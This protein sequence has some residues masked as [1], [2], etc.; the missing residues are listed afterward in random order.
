MRIGALVEPNAPANYRVAHP[1]EA[2]AR[3]GHDVVWPDMRGDT[4]MRELA[5]CDLVV[6]YRRCD[7]PNRQIISALRQ[8]GVAVIWDNDDDL[9]QMPKSR[10]MRRSTGGLSNQ[11]LFME[12][13]KTARLC[14]AVTTTTD[15]LADVFRRAGV[16]DVTVFPNML[17]DGSVR[18]RRQHANVTVGWIATREHR[19]DANG[20]GLTDVLTRLQAKHPQL[21]VTTVGVELGL[22]ERYG[23]AAVLPFDQLPRVMEDFDIGIAPLLDTPFNRTRSDIKVKEYAASQMPW[24]ASNTGP[25]AHLGERQGGRLVS[26]DGWFDALDELI[27]DA[28]ARR[29]LAQAGQ[30]WA[31]TQTIDAIAPDY[32]KFL[33]DV[34]ERATGK[35][36][37]TLVRSAVTASMHD[38]PTTGKRFVARIP[39]RLV[40]QQAR[41]G[42]PP[43]A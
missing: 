9:A 23:Y 14:H 3:R 29:D 41:D 33:S 12:M 34:V 5:T 2:M 19:T 24:L 11:R 15:A 18:P 28:G 13:M 40:T 35:R 42:V 7:P 4:P 39:R 43:R 36:P 21:G 17:K 1:L 26:D 27:T 38:Q 20:V 10:Q 6:V 30:G 8:R 22:R 31:L 37:A 16:S 25:Y 32:E